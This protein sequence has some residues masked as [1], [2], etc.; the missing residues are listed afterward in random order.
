MDR[1]RF[2]QLLQ[3]IYEAVDELERM[4]PGRHFT[5]DGHLVGSLG[6]ALAAY[7]YGI[8]LFEASAERHDGRCGDRNIQIKATQGNRVPLSSEPEHLLVIKLKRDGTFD[9]MYNGPGDRV[10]AFVKDKPK[11]K[12]GQYQVS[13]SLL[14]RCMREVP[15]RDR[16]PRIDRRVALSSD[17]RTHPM[18]SKHVVI[19][20]EGYFSASEMEVIK[21]GVIPDDMGD[22]WFIYWSENKLYFHRSWTGFC[23]YVLEIEAARTGHMAVRALVNRDA[24]QYSGTSDEEDRSMI[25]SIIEQ[26]MLWQLR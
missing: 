14:L 18:P 7:Y 17:W 23:V 1:Q 16:L 25:L 5:P 4:F 20:I 15:E 13:L 2:P 8:E 11:P 22:K 9:E 3:K 6:E 26:V 12:N 10:W 21:R 19:D 24:D